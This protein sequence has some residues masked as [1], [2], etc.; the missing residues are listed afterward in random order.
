VLLKAHPYTQEQ[1]LRETFGLWNGSKYYEWNA[2]A[3]DA[4]A[5]QGGR[6]RVQH[7]YA[8]DTALQG[9]TERRL[10]VATG[11]AHSRRA[12]GA[13]QRQSLVEQVVVGGSSS[14]RI[15]D[16]PIH[17]RLAAF[18]ASIGERRLRPM[19]QRLSSP[20]AWPFAERSRRLNVRASGRA[21][22]APWPTLADTA[23]P[24]RTSAKD[25]KNNQ[26]TREKRRVVMSCGRGA[27]CSW[28]ASCSDPRTDAG[29]LDAGSRDR[30]RSRAAHDRATHVDRTHTQVRAQVLMRPP[31]GKVCV[32]RS[33][34]HAS[35]RTRKRATTVQPTHSLPQ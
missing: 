26:R 3:A 27:A 17:C 31:G 6:L 18:G 8:R 21:N 28:L 14:I 24:P 12:A 32:G 5:R 33:T 20:I 4:T 16:K 34:A 35:L 10:R 23:D 15:P 25:Q 13:G 2:H 19:K 7:D 30:P 9:W 11:R 29:R 22:G 1:L